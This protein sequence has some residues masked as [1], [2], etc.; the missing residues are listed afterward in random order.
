M[1][2]RVISTTP[3]AS[4]LDAAK[5]IAEHHFDGIPV[6]DQD[7]RLLGLVTE[8]DLIN[9]TSAINTSIFQTIL[10]DIHSTDNQ[11]LGS[12]TETQEIVTLK[13]SDIMNKNPLTL[14]E[15]ATF[16]EAVELFKTHNNINP[17]PV[18]NEQGKMVGIISRFDILQ[19]LNVLGYSIQQK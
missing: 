8:Y 18:I 12:K 7:G 4:I 16:G 19:P 1:T 3:S 17:G 9:K 5:I 2:K 6:I 11:K 15:T 14:N 10:D 13:V